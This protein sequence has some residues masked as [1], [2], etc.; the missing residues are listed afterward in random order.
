MNNERNTFAG[1]PSAA[2]P[3]QPLRL[4]SRGTDQSQIFSYR[5]TATSIAIWVGPGTIAHFA[6]LKVT[7]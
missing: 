1:A 2:A 4:E 5:Q 7:P 6:D 3:P